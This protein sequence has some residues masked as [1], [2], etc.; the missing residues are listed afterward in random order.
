MVDQLYC[1]LSPAGLPKNVTFNYMIAIKAGERFHV[2]PLPKADQWVLMLDQFIETQGYSAT[3]LRAPVHVAPGETS[4]LEIDLTQGST[5][6]GEVRGSKGEALRSV[7]VVATA[8]D[9]AGRA[10]GAVTK[11]DG[12][13]AI[14]GLPDGD[15]TL[16]VKR[17]ARRTAPG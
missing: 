7:S 16:E 17:H 4:G 14:R 9:D 8:A 3:L 13:Y 5:L 2:G 12:K 15:Y 6:S 1:R 10:Y 11:A